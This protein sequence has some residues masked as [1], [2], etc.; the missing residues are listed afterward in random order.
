MFQKFIYLRFPI[1]FFFCLLKSNSCSLIISFR[2]IYPN[3][4]YHNNN[5]HLTNNV[6]YTHI[7][8][9]VFYGNKVNICYQ[10]NYSIIHVGTYIYSCYK[11]K[12]TFKHVSTEFIIVSLISITKNHNYK[13]SA[14]ENPAHF[15]GCAICKQID[16]RW[17]Q[18]D[19][20]HIF[21]N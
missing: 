13:L 2:P 3:S 5:I 17:M 4:F 8:L 9:S 15:F 19:S 11:L 10:P 21:I 16:L 12:L 1:L 14:G 20:V 6:Q 7:L 18:S